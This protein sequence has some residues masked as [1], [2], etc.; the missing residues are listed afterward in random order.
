MKGTDPWYCSPLLS[1]MTN[2]FELPWE[3]LSQIV[4]FQVSTICLP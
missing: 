2:D 3:E 4:K 1:A